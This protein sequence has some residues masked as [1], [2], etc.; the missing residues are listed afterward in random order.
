MIVYLIILIYFFIDAGFTI[1]KLNVPKETV[2]A[3]IGRQGCNIKQV[4][5][6][7]GSKVATKILAVSKP[8]IVNT[9]HYIQLGF[10]VS[11]PI[12]LAC[13]VMSWGRM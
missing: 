12:M 11:S 6:C 1:L 4:C 3:I 7:Y 13:I 2:G 5:I 8:L 10:F 9:Y